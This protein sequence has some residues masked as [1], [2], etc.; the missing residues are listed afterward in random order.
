MQM[1]AAASNLEQSLQA[2]I[3]ALDAIAANIQSRIGKMQQEGKDMTAATTALVNA[4][5][6]IA[7]AKTDL[8]TLQKRIAT[9]IT[10]KNPRAGLATVKRSA[11]L[12]VVAKIKVAHKALTDMLPLLKGG[13][14]PAPTATSTPVAQKATTVPAVPAQVR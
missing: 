9:M 8:A 12:G 13:A 14:A 10:S 4:Q 2:R 7:A 11:T 5:K 1:Q 3:A 6:A